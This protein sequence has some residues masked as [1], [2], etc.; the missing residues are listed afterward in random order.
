MRLVVGV[1]L[2]DSDAGAIRFADWIATPEGQSLHAFHVRG[3]NSSELDSHRDLVARLDRLAPCATWTTATHAL[4]ESVEQSIAHH[5]TDTGA[6]ALVVGQRA[7]GTA[8][9]L[10]QQLP[11]A[12]FVVPPDFR[13][14][15]RLDGP[16]V[17]ATDFESATGATRF[18]RSL[19]ERIRRPVVAVHVLSPNDPPHAPR[20]AWTTQT[21]L[22]TERF[23]LLHGD[24]VTAICRFLSEVGAAVVVCGSPRAPGAA[25]VIEPSVGSGLAR[26]A[27][28]PVAVVPD[29]WAESRGDSLFIRG[30]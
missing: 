23:E 7:R 28:C 10:L 13:M 6:D 19:V 29:T 24:P 14:D 18:T 4:L 9:R 15:D 11:I 3:S 1:G 8:R 22:R 2:G 17:L 21:R 25:G 30:G 16:I 27:V 20:L 26:H 12:T 5:A